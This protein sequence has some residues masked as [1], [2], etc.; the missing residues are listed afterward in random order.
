MRKKN[1]RANIK[2]P[3]G[4]LAM[5]K[6]QSKTP[7]INESHPNTRKIIRILHAPCEPSTE[8]SG[9]GYRIRWIF[10]LCL[11]VVIG[12]AGILTL[13]PELKEGNHTCTNAG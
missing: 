6:R 9:A 7:N 3:V 11:S 2:P 10:L 12:I 13:T 5:P 8:V 4:R 1:G